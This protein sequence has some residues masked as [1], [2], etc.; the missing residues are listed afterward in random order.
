MEVTMEN[1]HEK[2]K[3]AKLAR[4]VFAKNLW[5]R[6][7]HLLGLA[8][9]DDGEDLPSVRR[10][11]PEWSEWRKEY[12]KHDLPHAW[13]DKQPPEFMITV[14]TLHPPADMAE[15]DRLIAER[16]SRRKGQKKVEALTDERHA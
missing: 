15:I 3:R 8:I 11:S 12:D 9:E 7:L 14:T 6:R 1:R 2:R 5:W 16:K 4:G 10:D 13:V